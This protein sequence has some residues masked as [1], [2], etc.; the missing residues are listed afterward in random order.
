MRSHEELKRAIT[1]SPAECAVLYGHT[2]EYWRGLAKRGLIEAHK[3]GQWFINRESL[4]G[5]VA[6]DNGHKF[7]AHVACERAERAAK[8]IAKRGED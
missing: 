5:F 3:A 4:D 7:D 6:G 2:A 8:K 1:L